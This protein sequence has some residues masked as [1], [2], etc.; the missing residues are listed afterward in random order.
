MSADVED[1]DIDRPRRATRRP[2]DLAYTL[3]RHGARIGLVFVF[4]FTITP[5]GIVR[6][7]LGRSAIER[8][9]RADVCSYRV[10]RQ[11]RSGFHLTK[12]Y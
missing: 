7:W 6:S 12:Q 10:K 1:T 9:R 2:T 8:R 4:Y 5:I 11:A 3:A